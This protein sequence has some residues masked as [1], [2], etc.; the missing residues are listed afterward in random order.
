MKSMLRSAG[1]S[2]LVE[3]CIGDVSGASAFF[4]ALYPLARVLPGGVAPFPRLVEDMREESLL[5]LCP[6][7]S[8]LVLDFE[9]AQEA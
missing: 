8:L 3:F 2:N 1:I 9:K 6:Y 7:R 4:E 5:T